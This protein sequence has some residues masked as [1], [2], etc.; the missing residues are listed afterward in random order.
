MH[1]LCIVRYN[2]KYELTLYHIYDNNFVILFWAYNMYVDTRCKII[3]YPQLI[4]VSL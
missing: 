4:R 1:V 3:N 2:F